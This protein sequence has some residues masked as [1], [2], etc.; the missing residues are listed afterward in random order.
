MNQIGDKVKNE[1]LK[2][3]TKTLT[4]VDAD[5]DANTNT[6]VEGSTIALRKRCSGELIKIKI[7]SAAV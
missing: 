2:T 3:L 1:V 4:I 6:D 5:A 7:L